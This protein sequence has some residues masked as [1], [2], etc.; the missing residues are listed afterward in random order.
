MSPNIPTAAQSLEKT[1]LYSDLTIQQDDALAK[2]HGKIFVQIDQATRRAESQCEFT[3]NDTNY[4]WAEVITLLTRYG[5]K[6]NLN[7]DNLVLSI[8]WR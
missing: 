4:D 7:P 6:A 5:Y 8:T 3:T 2:K 1:R